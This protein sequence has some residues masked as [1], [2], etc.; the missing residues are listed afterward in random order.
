MALLFPEPTYLKLHLTMSRKLVG[1]AA[2]D[3]HAAPRHVEEGESGS[4]APECL[5]DM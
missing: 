2:V 5:Y 1:I 3:D 4:C